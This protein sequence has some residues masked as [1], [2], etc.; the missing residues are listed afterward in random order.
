MGIPSLE[1]GGGYLLSW[2][3]VRSREFLFLVKAIQGHRA[4]L[5][6]LVINL[7]FISSFR[8]FPVVHSSPIFSSVSQISYYY[9]LV[10]RS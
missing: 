2:I 4:L 5:L 6:L 10:R 8:G 3:L 1:R 9:Y 7:S